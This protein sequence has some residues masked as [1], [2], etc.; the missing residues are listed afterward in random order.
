M[1]STLLLLYL[2]MRV[3]LN[4]PGFTVVLISPKGSFP[5]DYCVGCSS[6]YLYPQPVFFNMGFMDKYSD[7]CTFWGFSEGFKGLVGVFVWAVCI[8]VGYSPIRLIQWRMRL[9]IELLWSATAGCDSVDISSAWRREIIQTLSSLWQTFGIKVDFVHGSC[10][11]IFAV[12]LGCSYE[13]TSWCLDAFNMFWAV[14][15]EL[16]WWLVYIEA[17]LS[18]DFI[19]LMLCSKQLLQKC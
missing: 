10:E 9:V 7:M 5:K 3:L 12:G 2:R 17:V 15:L 16:I 11:D 19:T 13:W 14:F 6:N 8:S 18:L 1:C 4:V